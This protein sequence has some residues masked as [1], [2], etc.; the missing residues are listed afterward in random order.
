MKALADWS[1]ST[2]MHGPAEM[3][4]AGGG[5]SK[6]AWAVVIVVGTT[7]MVPTLPSQG[8]T[9][10]RGV[11]VINAYQVLTAYVADSNWTTS[12]LEERQ[13][14]IP[15]P[16][17]TICNFNRIS[18]AKSHLPHPQSLPYPPLPPHRRRKL[19]MTLAHAQFFFSTVGDKDRYT[20]KAEV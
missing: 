15:F 4:R 2:T 12:V 16:A 19:N 1:G 17:V 8:H 9:G 11:Q 6:A 20:F 7:A 13:E 18:E 3:T 5:V 10:Q 14:A